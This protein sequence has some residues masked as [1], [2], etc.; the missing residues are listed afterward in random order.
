MAVFTAPGVSVILVMS[1]INTQ[2]LL[3]LCVALKCVDR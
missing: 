2:S 1:N 3:T